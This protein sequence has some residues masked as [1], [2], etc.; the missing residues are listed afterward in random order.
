MRL[1]RA[2]LV[3]GASLMLAAGLAV[4]AVVMT[5]PRWAWGISKEWL[6]KRV[7]VD[8]AEAAR[9]CLGVK[10]FFAVSLGLQNDQWRA[11]LAQMQEGDELWIFC[12]PAES[13]EHMAGRGGIAV[14]RH[15]K[16]VGTFVTLRQ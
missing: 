6:Q 10:V 2:L 5:V 9:I 3:A 14:V 4:A 1:R 15:G 16:V 8:E 12:S 7:T 13:W 11:F